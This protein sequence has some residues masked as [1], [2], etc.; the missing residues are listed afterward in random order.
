VTLWQATNE[1]ARDFRLETIGPAWTSTPLP[2]NNGIYT[3]LLPS[4]VKGWTA[5]MVELTFPGDLVFTTEVVV[6]PDGYPFGPPR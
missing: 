6:R 4:P 5:S 1:T 3:V 2:G